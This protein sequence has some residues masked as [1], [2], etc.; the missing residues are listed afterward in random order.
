MADLV[1]SRF[2]RERLLEIYF[3]LRQQDIAY[4]VSYYLIDEKIAS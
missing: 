3:D 1:S 2:L 4:L